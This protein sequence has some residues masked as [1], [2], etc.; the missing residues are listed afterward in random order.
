MHGCFHL[1]VPGLIADADS[2][3]DLELQVSGTVLSRKSCANPVVALC[4]YIFDTLRQDAF[5]IVDGEL[6]EAL[7][8]VLSPQV[9]ED[10]TAPGVIARMSCRWDYRKC[11]PEIYEDEHMQKC[12]GSGVNPETLLL[13]IAHSF[14]VTCVNACSVLRSYL[15]QK[16]NMSIL[17]PVGGIGVINK[18]A[19][20]SD[21][22]VFL[23]AGR[24]LPLCSGW[25][26]ADE[27]WS[28]ATR[29]TTTTLHSRVS[30]PRTLPSTARSLS[31]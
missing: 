29:H 24:Q 13:W 2:T 26:P 23:L 4:N 7:C 30:E 10:P 25:V 5:R 14:R 9:E 27:C 8:S 31:W 18:L 12:V 28:Q 21:G 19:S 17:I 11:T 20:L 15:A 6:Q 16:R 1:A 3:A 22:K